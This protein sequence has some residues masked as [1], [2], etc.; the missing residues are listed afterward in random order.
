M[1][2]LRTLIYMLFD[3]KKPQN[4]IFFNHF[5]KV[6]NKS[7]DSKKENKSYLKTIHGVRI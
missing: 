4:D 6:N 2:T 7:S 1:Y 3:K 5:G